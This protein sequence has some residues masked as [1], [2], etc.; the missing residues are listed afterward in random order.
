MLFLF[1][2]CPR[3]GKHS[4]ALDGHRPLAIQLVRI[5]LMALLLAVLQPL[6]L[7]VLQQAVLPA[8][9]SAAEP[10]VADDALRGVFAIFVAAADLLGGHPA[11]QG[12]RHVQRCVGRDSVVGERCGRG[13]QVLP[14]VHE[15]QVRGLGQVGAKSKQRAQCGDGGA[16]GY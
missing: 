5:P 13:R 3:K 2:S 10:A 9:V 4:N 15:A 8:K 12:Q 16:G 6:A 7:V 14:C 1:L 11:A